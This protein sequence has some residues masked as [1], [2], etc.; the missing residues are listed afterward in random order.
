MLG[1]LFDFAR[2]DAGGAHTHLLA[3]AGHQR[4]NLLQIGIPAPPARIIR[5]ADHVAKMRTFAANLTLHCH[6]CPA[7]SDYAKPIEN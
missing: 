5:V 3:S 1:S 6:C 2:A 7:S 4:A